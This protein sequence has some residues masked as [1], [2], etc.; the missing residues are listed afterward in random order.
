MN[1]NVVL[2]YKKVFPY[3]ELEQM[4]SAFLDVQHPTTGPTG[5]HLV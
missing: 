5:P 4:V 1:S 3:R 2:K